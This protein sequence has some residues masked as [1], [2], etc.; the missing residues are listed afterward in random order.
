MRRSCDYVIR[1]K[2]CT[3]YVDHSLHF[4]ILQLSVR[5]DLRDLPLLLMVLWRLKYISGVETNPVT[6]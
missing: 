5:P 6:V 3:A 4:Q 2:S 1:P